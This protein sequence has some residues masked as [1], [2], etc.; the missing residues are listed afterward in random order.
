MNAM[1]DRFEAVLFEVLRAVS[2]VSAVAAI[3]YAIWVPLAVPMCLYVAY[4]VLPKSEH[5]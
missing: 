5:R 4:L 1:P 2:G 3:V